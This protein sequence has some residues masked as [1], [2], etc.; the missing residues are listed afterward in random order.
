M[1]AVGKAVDITGVVAIV[2][3]IAVA[4]SIAAGHCSARGRIGQTSITSIDDA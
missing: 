1:E 4:S 3:G 2:V